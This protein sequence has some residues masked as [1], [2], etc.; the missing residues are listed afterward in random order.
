VAEAVTGIAPSSQAT[1]L[2]PSQGHILLVD[3]EDAIRRVIGT[4]LQRMGYQVTRAANGTEALAA[5]QDQSYDVMICDLCMPGLSG[6]EVYA[7][8]EREHPS[9]TDRVVFTSGDLE[10]DNAR[11]LLARAGGQAVQK[12]YDIDTLLAVIRTVQDSIPQ[13]Q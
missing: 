13:R 6:Q 4:L 10:T 11:A 1:P 7:Q 3:D 2:G 8:M 9:M 12:P 5:L